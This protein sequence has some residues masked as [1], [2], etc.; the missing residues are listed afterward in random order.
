MRCA[1]IGNH[2][3][4]T[5]SPSG[6]PP[7]E[8]EASARD[9]LEVTAA[10]QIEYR[11]RRTDRVLAGV[12]GGLADTLGV[13]DAFVR[14]AFVTLA[15]VWGLGVLVYLGLWLMA[16]DRVDDITADRVETHKALGL[17]I[18]FAGFM[19]VLGAA[20]WWPS[21]SLVITVGTLA[22]GVAAL[23]GRDT[24][25]PLVSLIDPTVDRPGRVRILIG[26]ALL[27][28]G[29][30]VFASNVGPLF[31]VGPVML[32]VGLTGVGILVAF[33]PWVAR[34]AS[35]LGNERRE[36]IRQEERAEVA[37]HLHDSVLQTLALIQRS[38][39]PSRMSML[40][41]HQESELRDWLYGNAPLEGVDLLSTALKS[42]AK[43]I[44]TDHQIPIDVVTV[45]DHAL[46]DVVRPIVGAASEAMVNAAKHSETERVSLYLEADEHELVVY[47]TDQGKG[48]DMA[49]VPADRRG[50][51][52]SI[53]A[54]MERAGGLAEV[55]SEPG[56]G[57]EVILR[58][59]V[60]EQ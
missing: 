40:A 44:E 20:G 16:L 21:N 7:I 60:G 13:S 41:R 43:R 5:P 2:P 26:V 50:I 22:F 29:L 17:G 37:A 10:R 24:P 54:R 9:H 51:S 12:A 18:A 1:S 47:V 52:E 48:F 49:T 32:A 15:M 25:G 57:T 42:V 34:L 58:M 19:L 55:V 11:R 59:P 14:A 8:V 28:G 53:S 36:R 31:D 56:E 23:T 39:D 38:D 45:G 6:K 27:I 4:R 30:A 46:D 33:G 3:E 35:D